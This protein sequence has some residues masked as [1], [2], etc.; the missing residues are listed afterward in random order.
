MDSFQEFYELQ[1]ENLAAKIRE[2]YSGRSRL[3][4]EA[5]QILWN[6]M[7]DNGRILEP[8]E[9]D[10]YRRQ[11]VA[12]IISR[13]AE[14]EYINSSSNGSGQV[15]APLIWDASQRE[16]PPNLAA[17]AGNAQ[18]AN[19]EAIAPHCDSQAPLEDLRATRNSPAQSQPASRSP[20]PFPLTVDIKGLKG[21]LAQTTATPQL[22]SERLAQQPCQAAGPSPSQFAMSAPTRGQGRSMPSPSHI[23]DHAKLMMKLIALPERFD[24]R[25]GRNAME[26]FGVYEDLCE[27]CGIPEQYMGQISYFALK[28]GARAFCKSQSQ[29]AQRNLSAIKQ[30]FIDRYLSPQKLDRI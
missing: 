23:G 7:R 12:A 8:A 22:V 2:T 26:D 4:G 19:A 17:L 27:F 21:A 5:S 16:P 25:E 18:S 14:L 20:N 15:G 24:G 9:N 3:N 13:E 1:G 29:E 11:R 28:D 10:A 30:A 6:L